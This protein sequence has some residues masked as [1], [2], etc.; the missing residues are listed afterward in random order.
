[1]REWQPDRWDWPLQ[2]NDG[3][4]KMINTP[5]KFEVGLEVH[6][7][8]PKEVEVKVA[9]M[10]LVVHCR[11]DERSDA[12]GTITREIFRS[13]HLPKDVDTGTLKSHLNQAGV[14]VITA[15]KKK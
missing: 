13:Y 11:H 14:L 10:E 2:H 4:V 12:H 6:Y 8:T 9:G 15:N 7:F 5:D 1:M 3:V